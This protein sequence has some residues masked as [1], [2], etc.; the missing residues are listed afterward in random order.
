MVTVVRSSTHSPTCK[1]CLKTRSGCARASSSKRRCAMHHRAR[2]CVLISQGCVN[3]PC[4]A[5]G[6]QKHFSHY[7]PQSLLVC[8]LSPFRNPEVNVIS[9]NEASFQEYSCLP[10]IHNGMVTNTQ[11]YHS[12]PAPLLP[13]VLAVLRSEV[14]TVFYRSNADRGFESHWRHKCILLLCPI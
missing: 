6:H 8:I 2:F 7:K 4:V 13:V 12:A 1:I 14:C 9:V 10:Y 5:T 3:K 11:Q